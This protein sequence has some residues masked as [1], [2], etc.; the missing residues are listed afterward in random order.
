MER[1]PIRL[2]MPTK[3]SRM[4]KQRGLSLK[5]LAKMLDPP[6]TATQISRLEAGERILT[7][8]WVDRLAPALGVSPYDLYEDSD[9]IV[10]SREREMIDALRRLEE[11]QREAIVQTVL[12]LSPSPSDEDDSEDGDSEDGDDL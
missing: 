4:R 11:S 7:Q 2:K 1:L 8:K 6:T 10:S 12:N 5:K 9:M 3:L